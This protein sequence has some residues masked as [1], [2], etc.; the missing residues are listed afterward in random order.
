M[1]KGTPQTVLGIQGHSG[2]QGIS[3]YTTAVSGV[4]GAENQLAS[5]EPEAEGKENGFHR[6]LLN[7]NVKNQVFSSTASGLTEGAGRDA[8]GS[9][10]GDI[11]APDILDEGRSLGHAAAPLLTTEDSLFWRPSDPSPGLLPSAG[12]LLDVQRVSNGDGPSL[13]TD[14]SA[15]PSLV[16]TEAFFGQHEDTAVSWGRSQVTPGA[17]TAV[18]VTELPSDDWDDTKLG[19]AGQSRGTAATAANR[20]QMVGGSY[21][22]EGR[23]E[24]DD[25]V[26]RVLPPRLPATTAR[27]SQT[28]QA[29]PVQEPEQWGE[30]T[31]L[32]AGQNALLATDL[33]PKGQVP[34]ARAIESTERVAGAQEAATTIDTTKSDVFQT[35]RNTLK[36]N[37]SSL[38]RYVV[39]LFLQKGLQ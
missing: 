34:P 14:A 36:G 38:K 39:F 35:L 29:G 33:S 37:L 19:A 7:P 17:A 24:D 1:V 22:G 25:E 31:T 13:A 32:L 3:V 30:L 9:L 2:H 6:S 26:K 27:G 18:P 28:L 8:T 23:E 21:P 15:K 5:S 4:A 10:G 16:S 11:F 12:P 20:S